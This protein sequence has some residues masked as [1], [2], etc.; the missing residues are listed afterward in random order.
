MHSFLVKCRTWPTRIAHAK[1]IFT[2][3]S[4]GSVAKYVC[5]PGYRPST[6]NNI[7]KCLYGQWTRE[8]PPFRCLAS[9]NFSNFRISNYGFLVSC[10]HPTKKF[11]LLEGGQIL[12][13]GQMGQ[14]DF[15]QYI[16]RVPDGKAIMFQC[17]K[18]NRLLGKIMMVGVSGVGQ[19]EKK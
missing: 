15:A 3:S 14:Y 18:G 5:S 7:I 16:N 11:G 10:E 2:K 4:H 12:L 13:E 9:R 6:S 1:V 19:G 17:N 8:G